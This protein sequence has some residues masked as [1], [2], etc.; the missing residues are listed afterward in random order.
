MDGDIAE[1]DGLTVTSDAVQATVV[2]LLGQ[3]VFDGWVEGQTLELSG[4]KWRPHAVAADHSALL[5]VCTAGDLPRFVIDRLARASRLGIRCVVALS[6]ANLYEPRVVPSLAALDVEVLVLDDYRVERRHQRRHVLAAVADIEVPVSPEVRRQI[7]RDLWTRLADG[8][9]NAKGSRLEACLAF[10]FSQVQDLRVVERN[11]RGASDE[12]DLVLQVDNHSNRAWQKPGVP[13]MLVEAKNR[14]EKADQ[15]DVSALITK[16]QTKRGSAKFGLLIAVAGFTSGAT[17]QEM[18]FAT[19]EHI[20]VPMID[21]ES[22]AL[23]MDSENLDD[24][25]EQ[26]VREAL[27]R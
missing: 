7:G 2:D 14:Q 22:L 20:C 5:Q 8:T 18:K 16:L 24:A 12:I 3:G 13:F 23:L 27:L 4:K 11:F 19:S 10:L 9:A 17:M 25:L 15:Q 21:G 26:I 1:D 6:I